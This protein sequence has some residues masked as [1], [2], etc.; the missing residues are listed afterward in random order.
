[1]KAGKRL[2][3][4]HHWC[5]L[6]VGLFLLIMSL[7]GSLLVFAEEIETAEISSYNKTNNES[8]AFYID[9]SIRH[10]QTAYPGWEIRLYDQP[11][12]NETIIYELRKDTESKKIY[13]HPTNGAFL[14]VN[15]NA[16]NELQ[17]WL[18]LLHYTLFAGTL[19]KIIVFFVGLM[20]LITLI[21]GLWVYRKSFMK[22][23]SF[24]TR[25]NRK[26][27]RG[28]F[29]SLHRIIGVWSI[30]FN[31]LMV[32]TGLVLSYQVATNALKMVPAKTITTAPPG[33]SIDRVRNKVLSQYADFNIHLVRVRPNS[34]QVQVLGRFDNDPSWYGHYYSGF[35]YNGLTIEEESKIFMKDLPVLQRLVKMCGPLHFGNYGGLVLKIFYS[36]LGLTPA[37]LSI[38]GFIIWIK[39]KKIKN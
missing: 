7:S 35:V 36:L 16:K 12:K 21:T 38:S 39:K 33:I 31:L 5:G 18:L 11:G 28:R 8:G 15:E 26:S 20:F 10:V 19:G 23:L 14:H 9:S 27:V 25:I 32:F 17:R 37:F 3:A 29:S 34:S 30:I 6:L 1:M 22:V 2:F 24:K 4:W 13:V